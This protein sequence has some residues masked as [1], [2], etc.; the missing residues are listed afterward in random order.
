MGFAY[1]KNESGSYETSVI[2]YEIISN[3]HSYSAKITSSAGKVINL[4]I[5]N[6]S[7]TMALEDTNIKFTYEPTE[8]KLGTYN[9]KAMRVINKEDLSFEDSVNSG[10]GS[11]VLRLTFNDDG[12]GTGFES[13]G[14]AGES[15]EFN[16]ITLVDSGIEITVKGSE[17]SI[18]SMITYYDNTLLMRMLE[19][20]GEITY[21]ILEFTY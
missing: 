16:Y 2:E 6:D 15:T 8:L 11:F 18:A 3:S 13:H 20:D 5:D 17:E 10:D 12:T 19:L 21:Y 7:F 9:I 14:D 4:D 1:L